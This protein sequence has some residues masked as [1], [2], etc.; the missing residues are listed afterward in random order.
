MIKIKT[1]A[2][3]SKGNAHIIES[4]NNTILLDAGVAFREIQ[5]AAGFNT[6]K[7][8]ACFVTHRHG[9]HSNATPMLIKRGI[10]VYAPKDTADKFNGVIALK[11]KENLTIGDFK[12][13]PFEVPHD[14]PCFGYLVKAGNEKL[15]YIV[16]AEYVPYTFKDIT[17][18]ML[19]ANHSRDI[20]MDR[21]KEGKL[22]L[23]LAERILKTHISIEAAMEFIKKNDMSRVKEI[24]LLH[25]SND[26]SDAVRFKRKVQEE[27]GAIVYA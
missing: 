1:I 21:A 27:T 20:V 25:L 15:L 7:I 23:K 4:E 12:I 26:N 19:E 2:S 5:Y 10:K 6:A 18:L 11:A 22:S 16:D 9:D 17:H 8:D 3:G 24:H 13:T 14:V